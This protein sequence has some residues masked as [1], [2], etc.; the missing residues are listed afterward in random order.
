MSEWSGT[1][2]DL[3]RQIDDGSITL[4]QTRAF[5]EHRNPFE[6]GKDAWLIKILSRECECHLD[7]FGREFGLS[8]FQ[9][10][11]K[12]YGKEMIEAWQKLGLEP[13][14]LPKTLMM[15][16]DNYPGW[17]TK[18][19]NWYY[20]NVAQGNILRDINGKLVVDEKVEFQGIT[21]LVDTRLKPAYDNSKQMYENDTLLGPIIEELRTKGKIAKYEFCP[22]SS[23]FGVSADEWEETVRPA[24]AEKLCLEPIQLRLERAI[25]GN[26][27]SQLYPHMP[28]KGDGSTNTWEWYEEYFMDRGSRLDGG[29]SDGS[30]LAIIVYYSSGDHWYKRSF[31]PLAVL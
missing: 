14:F 17:K 29:Y 4:E 24:L 18:P 27:I 22:Q 8:D 6:G 15:P 9:K 31:R 19:E 11:L 23:R 10:T 16:S 21:V 7:F 2:K 25:E 1:L 20:E 3:F 30:D 13:H 28:R 26:V 12:R 5:A